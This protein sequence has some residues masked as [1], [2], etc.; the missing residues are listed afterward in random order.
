MSLLIR[1]FLLLASVSCRATLNLIM[2][3]MKGVS[4]FNAKIGLDTER[5]Q[6]SVLVWYIISLTDSVV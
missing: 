4:G 1:L 5:S 2:P 6:G 3:E